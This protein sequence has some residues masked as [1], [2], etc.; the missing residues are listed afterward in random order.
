M[1]LRAHLRRKMQIF[2]TLYEFVKKNL[3]STLYI[4]A[5]HVPVMNRRNAASALCCLPT[6]PA[7]FIF[8][9]RRQN[10]HHDL[11]LRT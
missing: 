4:P 1:V 7:G 9:V 2:F 3:L 6:N 10:D 8:K 5:K 11:S